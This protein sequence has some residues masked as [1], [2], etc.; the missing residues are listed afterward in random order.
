[1]SGR[2]KIKTAGYYSS[3]YG[4]QG[5]SLVHAWSNGW[6]NKASIVFEPIKRYRCPQCGRLRG[7]YE[8]SAGSPRDSCPAIVG[9]SATHACR[10][11]T[12]HAVM[13]EEDLYMYEATKEVRFW[14][15][16]HGKEMGLA[17]N[18][19][20]GKRTDSASR[21]LGKRKAMRYGFDYAGINV[22]PRP[23]GEDA[24]T[25]IGLFRFIMHLPLCPSKGIRVRSEKYS[26]PLASIKLRK[27]TSVFPLFQ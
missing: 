16:G 5:R 3:S 24:S 23:S 27:R 12:S 10:Y 2:D 13:S 17:R 4:R 26:N 20:E 21:D 1:M 22:Q 8:G 15:T 14:R 19:P 6:T 9:N 25:S 18:R 11:L 7:G